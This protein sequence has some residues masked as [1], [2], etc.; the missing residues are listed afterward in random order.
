MI[1]YRKIMFILWGTLILL[2]I[3]LIL[4]LILKRSEALI[5]IGATGVTLGNLLVFSQLN[6]EENEEEHVNVLFKKQKK[7]A[8]KTGKMASPDNVK[9]EIAAFYANKD[10]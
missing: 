1:A 8:K 2:A 4:C 3:L 10:K 5:Y 7:S 9:K 6:R